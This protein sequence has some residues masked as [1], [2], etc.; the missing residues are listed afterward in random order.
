MIYD[1]SIRS[2][3]NFDQFYP[4]VGD[5]CGLTPAL[6]LTIDYQMVPIQSSGSRSPNIA[7]YLKPGLRMTRSRSSR[8]AS[9][10]SL[11]IFGRL[12]KRNVDPST[13]PFQEWRETYNREQ[14]VP[15][16]SDFTCRQISPRATPA[17][18]K[19]LRRTPK[20]WAK[21]N[22]TKIYGDVCD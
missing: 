16:P 6:A 2:N 18:N 10:P 21:G 3:I 4:K 13:I 8:P 19:G 17:S 14:K 22:Q 12:P 15:P 1:R 9:H 5:M 11:S 7:C 20:T